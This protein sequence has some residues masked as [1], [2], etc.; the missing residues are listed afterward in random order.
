V[1]DYG[2]ASVWHDLLEG[3]RSCEASRGFSGL[4]IVRDHDD[5]QGIIGVLARSVH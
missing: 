5:R 2:L 3:L 1:W 4:F